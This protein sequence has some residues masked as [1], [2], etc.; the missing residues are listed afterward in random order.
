MA[1]TYLGNPLLKAPGVQ[2]DF[3]KEQIEEYV[4][5]AKDAKYFIETYIKI[6]N[7]DKGLVSFN[8]Y[9]FQEKWLTRLLIIVSPYVNYHVRAVSL[10]QL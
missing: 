7:V 6:V 1:E 9:D 2:I 8:L 10:P 3:T 5:C 4:K